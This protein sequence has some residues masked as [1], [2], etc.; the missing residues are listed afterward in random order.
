MQGGGVIIGA[1]NDVLPINPN[2]A[3]WGRCARKLSSAVQSPRN[4]LTTNHR[5]GQQNHKKSVP[6]M[7]MR[8]FHTAS[9][10]LPIYRKASAPKSL[11]IFIALFDSTLPPA[12]HQHNIQIRP[13]LQ[14]GGTGERGSSGPNG[15]AESKPPTS[16]RRRHKWHLGWR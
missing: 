9:G 8:D 12:F 4:K 14:R 16:G 3:I 10:L 11:S 1:A 6:P 15:L 2:T 7:Y 5:D 13:A